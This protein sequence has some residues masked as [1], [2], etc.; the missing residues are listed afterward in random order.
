MVEYRQLHHW[1]I[2]NVPQVDMEDNGRSG[3]VHFLTGDLTA[4]ALT[5]NRTML[6]RLRDG[7]DAALARKP[8]AKRDR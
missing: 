8:L 6:E 2:P 4:I 7:I 3:S 5:M 1:D